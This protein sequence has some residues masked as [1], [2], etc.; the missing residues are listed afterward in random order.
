MPRGLRANARAAISTAPLGGEAGATRRVR[1]D[2]S[3]LHDLTQP[4]TPTLSPPGRGGML[5][6]LR[7]RDHA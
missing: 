4:L 5:H 3:S 2:E 6:A 7:G 1:G